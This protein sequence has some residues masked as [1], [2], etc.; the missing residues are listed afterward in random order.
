M[1]RP[2]L[3]LSI[4]ARL[5]R[6]RLTTKGMERRA[7][8]PDLRRPKWADR[9]SSTEGPAICGKDR[10]AEACC[11]VTFRLPD[12]LAQQ[13]DAAALGLLHRYYGEPFG[14]SPFTGAL[15]DVWDSTGTRAGDADRFTADDLVAVTFLSLDPPSDLWGS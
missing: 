8:P 5:I 6:G 4:A 14:S 11:S 9:S 1:R 7:C 3:L 10:P 13:D 15:F 2:H 12:A